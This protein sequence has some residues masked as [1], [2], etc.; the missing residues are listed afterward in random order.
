M[1]LATELPV[2]RMATEEKVITLARRLLPLL[3]P[4]VKCLLSPPVQMKVKEIALSR[5]TVM[6]NLHLV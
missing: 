1:L 5:V 2:A 4:P 6:M 3:P